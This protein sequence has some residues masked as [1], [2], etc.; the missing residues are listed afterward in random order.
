MILKNCLNTEYIVYIIRYLIVTNFRNKMNKTESLIGSFLIAMPSMPDPRFKQS[1]ILITSYSTEG[2]TGII[3][4]KPFEINIK[5]VLKNMKLETNS[6][7][8]DISVL[9]GGL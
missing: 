1:V 9:N 3:I 8:N 7:R 4:N 6:S 2:A 5:E